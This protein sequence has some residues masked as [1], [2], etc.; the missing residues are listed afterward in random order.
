MSNVMITRTLAVSFAF[1]AA[2]AHAAEVPA[3]NAAQEEFF[4]MSPAERRAAFA[5]RDWRL[6]AFN[7]DGCAW[8]EAEK[9]ETSRFVR[10]GKV[11]NM[12]DFGGMK[13]QDGKTFRRGMLFRSAGLNGNAKSHEVTNELGKVTR[14]YYG[15]GAER[16]DKESREFATLK[17]GLRTD[18]D[19]RSPGECNGMAMSPLGAG[20]RWVR[21]SFLP[22]AELFTPAGKAAFAEAFAV[23]LDETNY[24][25][26]FHCISGA[27]RT[28]TLAFI[29]EALCG[30]SGADMLLDWEITVFSTKNMG[31]AHKER[32]DRL[33]EGFMKYP[34]ATMREKVEAFVVEQGFTREEIDR[35]R[36]FLLA[37]DMQAIDVHPGVTLRE[38]N[39]EEPR[40]MAAYIARIDLTTPGIGFAV[41]GRAANWGMRVGDDTN[42]FFRVETER[43]T[44]AGFMRRLRAGGKD[45]SVAVNVTGWGPWP[46][47][48]TPEGERFA[49][50]VAWVVSDGVEVSAPARNGACLAVCKNGSVRILDGKTPKDV[51]DVAFALGGSLIMANG[52]QSFAGKESVHPRTAIGLTAD[53]KTLVIL[54]VDGRTPAYSRGAM[55]C[56]LCDILKCEGVADALNMDGG[57]STSLVV[58]DRKRGEPRMV[59]RHRNGTVRNVAVNFGI[60]FD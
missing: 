10:L 8:R 47:P 29:V 53:R 59:N 13:T 36:D 38:L 40:R 43:E 2:I 24:P 37:D 51:R 20:V 41:T 21:T 44:T 9:G 27:D 32:Y 17:L 58:F 11:P 39:L 14:R 4:R 48:P 22:Y 16:L 7:R 6:A 33:V 12:R 34:G 25:L 15:Q 54:A 35:L 50:P 23:L 42:G 30:V 3:W 52:V 60:I 18:L 31:F 56:D 26:V 57:G 19:L 1:L 49:D 45:V 5:D 55:I 28:G 46:S